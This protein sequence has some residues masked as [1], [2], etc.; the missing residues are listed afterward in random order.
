MQALEDL[1]KPPEQARMYDQLGISW[2]EVDR[3]VMLEFQ[4]ALIN[5]LFSNKLVLPR[6]DGQNRQDSKDGADGKDG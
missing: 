2:V 6:H 1:S 5:W 3:M 4:V